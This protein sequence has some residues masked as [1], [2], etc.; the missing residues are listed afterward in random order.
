MYHI[1]PMSRI[2]ECVFIGLRPHSRSMTSPLWRARGQYLNAGEAFASP[3][4]FFVFLQ[5]FSVTC[6]SIDQAF[7]VHPAPLMAVAQR[8]RQHRRIVA[9]AWRRRDA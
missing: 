2:Y 5:S 7:D 1:S 9:D 6:R 4:S 8:L 3:A